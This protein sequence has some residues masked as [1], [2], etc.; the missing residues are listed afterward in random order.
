M[1]PDTCRK[2]G[3]TSREWTACG[4]GAQIAMG[5]LRPRLGRRA[6][7][8]AIKIRRVH[9]RS[10]C[11]GSDGDYAPLVAHIWASWKETL[12]DGFSHYEASGSAFPWRMQSLH[13]TLRMNGI[14]GMHFGGALG[15]GTNNS[16]ATAVLARRLYAV[17]LA[18]VTFSCLSGHQHINDPAMRC[19]VVSA[20]NKTYERT[21]LR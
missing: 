1:A 10:G 20:R 5:R 21:H 3:L 6:R 2:D 4:N 18:N 15:N 19:S 12:L 13:E 16:P 14:S 17:T 9:S 7:A 11:C 8:P